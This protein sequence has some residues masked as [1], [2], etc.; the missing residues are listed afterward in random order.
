[1]YECECFRNNYGDILKYGNII[2]YLQLDCDPPN[3][4]I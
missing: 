2:D 3:N 4:N 1:M